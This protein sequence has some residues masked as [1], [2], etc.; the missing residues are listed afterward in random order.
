MI[1]IAR[2]RGIYNKV[3][4]PE[5]WD[6]VSSINKAILD[7]FISEYKQRKKAKGTINQYFSD[8]RSVLI[9]ILQK[10]DN[11]SILE[12]TKKD[13]R[14][15]SLHLSEEM[16]LSSAR[17]NRIKSAVNSMLTFVE[18]D[19]EDYKDYTINI[20]KKVRGLPKEPVKTDE[21]NFFFT[22]DEFIQVRDKLVEQQDLQTAVMWSIAFDSGARKNEVYQIE[23]QGLLNG[24]QTNIVVGKRGKRFSLFYLNDTKELIKQYLEQRGEDDIN[25]LWIQYVKGEKFPIKYES[26]YNRMMKCNDILSEIRGV[27][28]FIFFHSSR[29]SRVEILSQG[30]DK[31]MLNTD[32]NCRKFTLEEIAVLVHHENISTTQLYVKNHDSDLIADMFG[33][34]KDE[35][36]V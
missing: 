33:L 36:D 22:F 2:S 1:V 11:K 6:Q 18:E 10:Y 35:G 14:N 19:E 30:L 32:G 4:T 26:M 21:D 12:L 28:T 31:R 8:I 25:S 34:N 17:T 29:H 3:Y 5:L 24:N 27:E 13:F 9:Y 23:K 7:D 16:Q 20:A 15:I